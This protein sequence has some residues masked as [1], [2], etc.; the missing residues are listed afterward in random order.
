M[1]R[2]AA[3]DVNLRQGGL[4]IERRDTTPGEHPFD[5]GEWEIRDAVIG[6]PA[7]PAF[8]QRGV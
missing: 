3:S 6:D 1:G 7:N 2:S 8:E 4:T 5:D